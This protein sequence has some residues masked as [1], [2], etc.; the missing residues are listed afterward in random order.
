MRTA[1]WPYLNNIFA[2]F[3]HRLTSIGSG[4]AY[5]NMVFDQPMYS[6]AISQDDL[7]GN[8]SRT[9]GIIYM[10]PKSADMVVNERYL[11]FLDIRSKLTPSPIRDAA[12][13]RFHPEFGPTRDQRIADIFT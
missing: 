12:G 6:V 4:V 10:F 3:P 2:A 5:T 9:P 7:A 1:I 8:W 11:L 13:L